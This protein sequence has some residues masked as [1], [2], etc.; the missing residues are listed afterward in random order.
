MIVVAARLLAGLAG[1]AILLVAA[2]GALWV[3]FAV[4]VSAQAP[5]PFVIDG[6]PCCGHPDTWGEVAE[7]A[8]WALGLALLDGLL[9]ALAVTLLFWAANRR[10]PRPKRLAL[11]PGGALLATALVLAVLVVPRLDEA[12]TAPPCNAVAFSRA[13]F[14]SGEDHERR[15]MAWAVARCD[16]VRGRTRSQV[17]RLLGPPRTRARIDRRRTFWDYGTLSVYF[18]DGRVTDARA[19]A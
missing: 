1:G 15:T 9:V 5:D 17:G 13:A 2:W 12:V 18:T 8:A 14:Q 16:L 3:M 10:R 19:I 6:D 4:A 11:L 7:G